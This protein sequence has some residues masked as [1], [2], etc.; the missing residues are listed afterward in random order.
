MICHY[1]GL[2]CCALMNIFQAFFFTHWVNYEMFQIK[3]PRGLSLLVVWNLR[4]AT[5]EILTSTVNNTKYE[6]YLSV[7]ATVGRHS[8]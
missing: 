6:H 4:E 8:H 7:F 5:K 3:K 2:Y 1:T